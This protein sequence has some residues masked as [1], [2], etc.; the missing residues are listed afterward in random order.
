MPSLSQLSSLQGPEQEDDDDEP[1]E[2][3]KKTQI[4]PSPSASQQSPLQAFLKPPEKAQFKKSQ[5]TPS[6]AACKCAPLKV[7]NL[8]TRPCRPPQD[9]PSPSISRLSPL[10]ACAFDTEPIRKHQDQTTSAST[11]QKSVSEAPDNQKITEKYE[12]TPSHSAPLETEDANMDSVQAM[13]V[14][15][16]QPHSSA[17]KVLFFELDR[18]RKAPA[19]LPNLAVD[20]TGS[21]RTKPKAGTSLQNPWSPLYLFLLIYIPMW[22]QTQIPPNTKPPHTILPLY[23]LLR[24]HKE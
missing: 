8:K 21:A 17:Q 14:D 18:K 19:G 9:S 4:T 16:T 10:H 6:L 20:C 7:F 15:I 13:T 1:S 22:I 5:A 2:R 11:S 12:E 3:G 23:V 24:G